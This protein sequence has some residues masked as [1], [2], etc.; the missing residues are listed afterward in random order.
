MASTG[1][2]AFRNSHVP[3]P[4]T[5]FPILSASA[6][7]ES[8]PNSPCTAIT[9]SAVRTTIALRASPIPVATATVR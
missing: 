1:S 3:S 9:T 5:G 7:S 6:I 2:P 8:V 4:T